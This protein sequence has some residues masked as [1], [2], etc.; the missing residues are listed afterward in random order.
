[1]SYAWK[2]V[3][4][5]EIISPTHVEIRMF[6]HLIREFRSRES[7]ED[8]MKWQM[9]RIESTGIVSLYGREASTRSEMNWIDAVR[10]V[11]LYREMLNAYD[12]MMKEKEK[13]V[14]EDT[15]QKVEEEK[16]EEEEE[17]VEAEEEEEKPE[18]TTDYDYDFEYE[19]QEY[20]ERRLRWCCWC[21][22]YALVGD[23]ASDHEN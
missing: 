19:D 1:M 11:E 5:W 17:E 22:P 4:A 20:D 3:Y 13:E 8:A 14:V 6:N 9:E 18:E 10:W 15:V 2:N 7:I 12:T 21:I 16:P 23:R